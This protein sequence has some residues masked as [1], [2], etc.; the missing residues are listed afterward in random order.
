LTDELTEPVK[1]ASYLDAYTRWW[2][3]NIGGLPTPEE[4]KAFKLRLERSNLLLPEDQHAEII[5]ADLLASGDPITGDPPY[6]PQTEAESYARRGI[7]AWADPEFRKLAELTEL[8]R[9]RLKACRPKLFDYN[10]C[11]RAISHRRVKRLRKAKKAAAKPAKSRSKVSRRSPLRDE[12]RDRAILAEIHGFLKA[13]VGVRFTPLKRELVS[14]LSSSPLLPSTTAGR[15]TT[16]DPVILLPNWSKASLPLRAMAMGIAAGDNGAVDFTL[17][18]GDSGVAYGLG[19]GEMQFARRLYRRIIDTLARECP[20]AG[21]PAPLF[22]FVVEKGVRER[23]HLHGVIFLPAKKAHQKHLRKKLCEAVGTDWKPSGRDLTQLEFGALFE[24]AG[25]VQYVTKY[26]ELTK[27]ELGD[28]IFAAPRPLTRGGRAWY[29]AIRTRRGLLLPG[30]A[31][32][33]TSV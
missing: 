26:V 17:H 10:A 1:A 24:P 9:A 20:E 3:Q 21:Y 7:D 33:T 6:D 8:G 30:K 19:V 14:P 29:E 13:G 16:H 22:F 28:N 18:L 31:V 4:V 5:H 15:S 27:E 12:D 11:L 23:P 2:E 32:P 25:W